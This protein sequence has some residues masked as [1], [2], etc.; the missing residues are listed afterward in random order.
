M[1]LHTLLTFG[2]RNKSTPYNFCISISISNVER[3][4][5]CSKFDRN[6]P[7]DNN[8]DD[9]DNDDDNVDDENGCIRLT[10]LTI[11][12]DNNDD[13]CFNVDDETDVPLTNPVAR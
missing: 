10:K 4:R 6:F 12:D 11:G 5:R 8:D 9:V 1:L 2:S 7:V 3:K 13:D